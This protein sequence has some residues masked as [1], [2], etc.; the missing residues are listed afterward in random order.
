M[1]GY[2]FDNTIFKGDS[3]NRFYFFVL[4]RN[5]YLVLIMPIQ[6]L[7]YFGFYYINKH[8]SK[9]FFNMFLLFVPLKRKYKMIDE[10]WKKNSDRIKEFYLKQKKTDDLIISASPL[11]LL[12]PIFDTLGITNYI[13]S[14]TNINT[15]IFDGHYCYGKYKVIEFKKRYPNTILES[16]YSDS[17]SDIPMMNQS[18]VGYFVKGEKI[19]KRVL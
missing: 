18:K 7:G 19:I 3:Y 17:S 12:K 15:G 10:F 14:N 8:I 13:T 11:F 2:D 9:T 4:A 5:I 16:F 6:F 1:N